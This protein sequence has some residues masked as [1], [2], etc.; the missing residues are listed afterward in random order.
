MQSS[1]VS[2][3]IRRLVEAIGG[4]V[5]FPHESAYLS[6]AFLFLSLLDFWLVLCVQLQELSQIKF[7]GDSLI[8]HR[9]P[10][11]WCVFA[12]LSGLQSYSLCRTQRSWSKFKVT[13]A[14]PPKK[15]FIS[16]QTT[17]PP[18]PVSQGEKGRKHRLQS[19]LQPLPGTWAVFVW[20]KETTVKLQI[21]FF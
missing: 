16:L 2:S 14:V 5:Q 19:F 1:K 10:A 17:E 8:A 13:S 21:L 11:G 9:D 18:S 20:R 3:E 15:C 7:R 6:S 4:T 12:I